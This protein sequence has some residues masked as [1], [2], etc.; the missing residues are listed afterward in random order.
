MIKNTQNIFLKDRIRKKIGYRILVGLSLI[1]LAIFIETT[2]EINSEINF[3]KARLKNLGDY[4]SNFMVAQLLVN[5]R[6]PPLLKIKNFNENNKFQI[7]WIES[8][9]L[10]NPNKLEWT[11]PFSWSF[12]FPLQKI[13][14]NN[15]GYLNIQ[16]SFI[17]DHNLV[18]NIA[19]KMILL[20]LFLFVIFLILYPLTQKIPMQLIVEPINKILSILLDSPQ[21]KGDYKI[22]EKT[23]EIRLIEEKIL[24][25][26]EVTK[27]KSR[28]EAIGKIMFQV[29]H[30]IRSPLAAL[31]ILTMQDTPINE[32]SKVLMRNAVNRIRDIA[33]DIVDKNR[34]FRK[35]HVNMNDTSV[36]LLAAIICPLITEK[37]LQFRSSPKVNIEFE[38][39]PDNYGVFVKIQLSE[40][41]RMLSN[42]IDNAIEALSGNGTVSVRIYNNH[43]FIRLVVSDNG[44]GIPPALLNQLGQ[45]GVTYNKQFGSGLGL[46]HAKKTM[47]QFNGKLEIISELGKGTDVI[48]TFPYASIPKWFYPRFEITEKSTLVILDDDITIHQLWRERFKNIESKIFMINFTAPDDFFDWKL[49]NQSR[50]MSFLYLIDLKFL[51][52][53]KTGIKII[54]ECN[55]QK[56]S[57]LVTSHFEDID[58]HEQCEKLDIKIIPKDLVVFVPIEF[59]PMTNELGI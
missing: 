14:N 44:R 29:A 8:D 48:M 13:G 43:N 52:H 32:Q 28:I 16:G 58:I 34:D 35:V 4:F 51:G 7:N 38:L 56:N 22:R 17:S 37:R 42:I 46:Y 59:R 47:E 19:M 53:S 20:L 41:K 10:P 45:Y 55:I 57:I 3:L 39:T 6:E 26:I 40:F 54:E 21:K 24:T 25:L 11:F 49:T 9:F 2:F 33:N 27:E 18:K 50:S 12:N 23:N 30:D 15:F 36:Q 31:N 1:T 5:D